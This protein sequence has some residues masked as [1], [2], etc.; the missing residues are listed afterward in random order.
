M[1]NYIKHG[2]VYI[3]MAAEHVGTVVEQSSPAE[4]RAAAAVA[5]RMAVLSDLMPLDVDDAAKEGGILDSFV[6]D[7]ETGEDGALHILTGNTKTTR[8]GAVI[9]GGF[10]HAPSAWAAW[11]NVADEHGNV[12]PSTRTTKEYGWRPFEPYNAEVMLNGSEKKVLVRDNVTGQARVVESSS[13]MFPKEYDAYMV[14]KGV[15]EAA[16]GRNRQHDRVEYSGGRAVISNTGKMRLVD[17]SKR[18]N[19]QLVLD[20]ATGKIITAYPL[21]PKK[22]PPY[23][24]KGEAQQQVFTEK[25][26]RKKS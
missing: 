4:A 10:H 11:P 3:V 2:I 26:Y 13:S 23:M 15:H 12:A 19:V 20:K 21:I 17:G 8:R 9:T 16:K 25:G 18:M 6:F 1:H 24:P 7:P 14:L 5:A 22:I